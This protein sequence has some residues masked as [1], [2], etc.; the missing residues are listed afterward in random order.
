M[1]RHYHNPSKEVTRFLP[2]FQ[3]SIIPLFL[4]ERGTNPVVLRATVIQNAIEIPRH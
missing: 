2:F 1:Q 3:N 4:V